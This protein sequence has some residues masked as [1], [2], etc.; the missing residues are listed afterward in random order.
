MYNRRVLCAP[1]VVC[2][3]FIAQEERRT[4]CS[5]FQE[6]S[7]VLPTKRFGKTTD[8]LRNISLVKR[9]SERTK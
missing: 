9:Q 4:Q 6:V 8:A 3:A 1:G 5:V 7:A 2:K